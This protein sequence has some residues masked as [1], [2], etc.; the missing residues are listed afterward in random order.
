MGRVCRTQHIPGGDPADRQFSQ[1]IAVAVDARR[2][3]AVTPN[4]S[5]PPPRGTSITYFVPV[6]A[7]PKC[8]F[9]RRI[10]QNWLAYETLTNTPAYSRR[11]SRCRSP[12]LALAFFLAQVKT[13]P[14]KGIAWSR[15]T[16][17]SKRLLRLRASRAAISFSIIKRL[18][19]KTNGSPTSKDVFSC[20]IR[21]SELVLRLFPRRNRGN[22]QRAQHAM[23][24]AF[25]CSAIGAIRMP[26][27]LNEN[28]SLSSQPMATSR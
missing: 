22:F 12:S 13:N 19:R 17:R 16:T 21:A 8:L 11:R 27:S 14:N 15:S 24:V 4:K 10:K 6:C 23:F 2:V 25:D 28:I 18:F 20:I 26:S 5:A 3:R 9:P 7:F 1:I